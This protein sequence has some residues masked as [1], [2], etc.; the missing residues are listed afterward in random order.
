MYQKIMVPV[1]LAHIERLGKALDTA[2]DLAKHYAIPVCYVG[3][4][5]PMPSPVAHT[6]KEYAEKLARFGAEQAQKH[7]I[8]AET[9]SYTSHD[10][11]VDLDEKLLQAVKDTRSDLIVMASHVPGVQEHFFA[12]NAGAVASHA[13]ISVFVI[14]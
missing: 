3:V 6:P 11:A 10:P 8:S 7:G 4:T 12:S 1:D 2:T 13:D 14:R 9:A 5:V